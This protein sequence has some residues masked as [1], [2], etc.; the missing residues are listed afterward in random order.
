MKEFSLK[1]PDMTCGHCVA[2]VRGALEQIE[3]IQEVEVSLETKT[4]SARGI[5]ELHVSDIE[6]AVRSAGYTPQLEG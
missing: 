6:A 5:D 4:V 3:G 2:A 1:V